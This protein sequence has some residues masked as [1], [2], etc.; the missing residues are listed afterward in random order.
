MFDAISCLK[1]LWFF[2]LFIP[3]IDNLDKCSW[4]PKYHLEWNVWTHVLLIIKE[5]NKKWIIDPDMYWLAL[6]HDIWKPKT[7]TKKEDWNISYIWHE[8]LSYE[9]FNNYVKK[10]K[11]SNKQV[12]KIWWIIKNHLLFWRIIEMKKLKSRKLFLNKHWNS[13][14][15]FCSADCLGRLPIQT[16]MVENINKMYNDFIEKYEQSK[17]LTG[18]DIKQKYPKLTWIDIWN[19]LEE[20]NNK[21]IIDI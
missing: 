6:F 1:D 8:E 12:D 21:I 17:L 9:I 4:W 16:K 10:L 2:K 19:K 18:E 5:L 11:F 7:F 20:I 3:E 15:T 14:Y 13:F